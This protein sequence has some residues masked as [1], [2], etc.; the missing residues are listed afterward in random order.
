[1]IVTYSLQI[2]VAVLTGIVLGAVCYRAWS[3]RMARNKR[4]IP[5]QWQLRAKLVFTGAE[6]M[7]WY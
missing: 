6:R 2:T 3:A 7:V 5:E 1:M 4:R